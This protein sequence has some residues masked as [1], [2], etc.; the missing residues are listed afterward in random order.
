MAELSLKEVI[1]VHAQ[2]HGLVFKP[3]PDR[4]HDFN[5]IYEFGNVNIIVDSLNEK[6]YAQNEETWSLESLQGLLELHNK[7]LGKRR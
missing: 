3:K 7:A 2:Q 4:M 5:Q 1:E 6:I